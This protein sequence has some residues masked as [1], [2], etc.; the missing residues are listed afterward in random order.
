MNNWFLVVVHLMAGGIASVL[1][2]P[3]RASTSEEKFVKRFSAENLFIVQPK[4][5]KVLERVSMCI[6]C[7][8]CESFNAGTPSRGARF[9]VNFA[10]LIMNTRSINDINLLADR[11]EEMKGFDLAAMEENCPVKV[12]FP[13]FVDLIEELVRRTGSEE[14]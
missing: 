12:P 3:M 5:R 13:A 8:R 9:P 11:V 10:D 7:G 1:S 4:T 14:A 6:S 2:Y